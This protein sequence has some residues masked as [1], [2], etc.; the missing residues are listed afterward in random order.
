MT[1]MTP[2]L[3]ALMDRAPHMQFFQLCRLLELQ[4]PERPGLGTQDHADHEPV[5]FRPWP[6]MGFPASEVCAVEQ[7]DEHPHRP[8]DVRT[9]FM[10][11]YGVD[12]AMPSHLINNIAL[13]REGHEAVMAFLDTYHHRLVTL[14]HRAWSKY[15]YPVGF[16]PGGSDERSRDLLALVGFGLGN[17]PA[18]AG[19]PEAR[20]LALLGLLNQRTRTAGGLAGVVALAVPGIDVDVEEF[21]PV[22]IK[23][24]APACL[25]RPTR[26]EDPFVTRGLGQGDVIGRRIRCRTKTVRITLRP[27]SAEQVEALLPGSIPYRDLMGFLRAYI[28]VKA[29]AVL[30]MRVDSTLLP[31][32]RLGEP[33][34][35]LAWTTLLR[36]RT[37]Q[38]LDI[39]LGRY[40]A[41]PSPAMTDAQT[42]AAGAAA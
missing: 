41:F 32:P 11:L 24:D 15:R 18:Q 10:G 34:S 40:E 28:G 33:R 29:D 26:G 6:R 30:R 5:R 19:L 1:T 35:R 2:L 4:A 8:P 38:T 12:A 3:P 23:V 7:D 13:R 22:W 25:G 20:V 27:R 17:K 42:Y 36:P 14:L 37:P 31:A 39:S 9:T 21:H 16:A